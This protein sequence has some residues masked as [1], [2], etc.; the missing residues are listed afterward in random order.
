MVDLFLM[1][2]PPLGLDCSRF[3]LSHLEHHPC[4]DFEPSIRIRAH[5]VSSGPIIHLTFAFLAH[6][7][8]PL[9]TWVSENTLSW[10]TNFD[11][12]IRFLFH[13]PLASYNKREMI[14]IL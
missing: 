6:S 9:R 13:A 14:N 1:K 11:T 12:V 10:L 7:D 4:V 8:C 2:L 3:T 5:V